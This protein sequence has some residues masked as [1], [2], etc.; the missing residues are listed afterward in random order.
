MAVIAITDSETRKSLAVT[1]AFGR[2]GHNVINIATKK[3]ILSGSSKYSKRSIYISKYTE[4]NIL[5]IIKDNNVD[6]LIPCEEDTM[7]L[8][9]GSKRISEL[10]ECINPDLK[11]FNICRDKFLTMNHALKNGVRIPRTYLAED[12]D[13]LNKYISALDEKDFPIVLKPRKGSGSRGIKVCQNIEEYNNVK[14]QYESSDLGIP[15]VQEFI[16]PG[17]DAIGASFLYYQGKEV[18]H[19]VHRRIREFPVSG[20]PSTL[21]ESII[22]PEAIEFG[23]RLL[24]GLNWNGVAMVEFKQDPRSGEL[25]LMEINPRIWGSFQLPIF[26]GINFPEAIIDIFNKKGYVE[27]K[28]TYREGIKLRWLFPADLLSILSSS[29]KLLTKFS[30]IITPIKGEV[31]GMI[32]DSKDLKP[33]LYYFAGLILD[34]FKIKQLKKKLFR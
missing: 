20:G 32:F 9:A 33:V 3:P 4:E 27:Y 19:F 13:E 25:V 23:R 18:C 26:S 6:I 16:P 5:K 31:T 34:T 21:C 12:I 28:K 24:E 7:E 29:D 14:H 15:M 1:R 17:G 10:T 30:K 11:S 8:V 2:L 22:N